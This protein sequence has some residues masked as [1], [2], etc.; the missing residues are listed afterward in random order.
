M[1]HQIFANESVDRRQLKK[2]EADVCNNSQITPDQGLAVWLESM[3][4]ARFALLFQNDGVRSMMQ[5]YERFRTMPS[6]S[7]G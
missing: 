6:V 7:L 3:G 1:A 4:K 2:L 5:L